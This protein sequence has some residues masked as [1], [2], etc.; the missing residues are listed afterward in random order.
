[1]RLETVKEKD[2]QNGPDSLERSSRKPIPLNLERAVEIGVDQEQATPAEPE[3]IES[4]RRKA[5]SSAHATRPMRNDFKQ[6]S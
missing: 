5:Y 6:I 1:V 2:Q 4:S 3:F